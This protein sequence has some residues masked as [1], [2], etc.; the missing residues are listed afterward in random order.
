MDLYLKDKTILVT[1]GSKGIG[2]A[3]AKILAIEGAQVLISSRSRENLELASKEILKISGIKP[4]VFTADVS[5]SESILE[6]KKQVIRSCDKLD[7]LVINAGG[8][9][10][11]PPLSKSDKDWENAFKTNFLSGVRLTREFIPMMQKNRFGRI[12][13]ITSTGMKQPLP[14]LVLS[15]ANRLGLAGYLKTISLE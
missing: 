3:C 4:A 11:G 6:L 12:V 1:G 2:F 7:G 13:A 14:N 5:S 15:N 10:A 8:P 9:P